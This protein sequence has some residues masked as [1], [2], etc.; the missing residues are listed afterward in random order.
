MV[1]ISNTLL[2][3]GSQ[4]IM[5]PLLSADMI[6]L[7][8]DLVIIALTGVAWALT[9]LTQIF[10]FQHKKFPLK[11]PVTIYPPFIAIVNTGWGY[12]SFQTPLS[13]SMVPF[14]HVQILISFM[15]ATTIYQS[16][17]KNLISNISYFV[18]FPLAIKGDTLFLGS[19]LE[20]IA[21]SIS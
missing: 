11:T 13:A 17:G 12:Y 1:S 4:P 3:Y 16:P 8:A 5:I 6:P 14:F 10:F 9:L 19:F 18:N 20:F 2:N 21:I 7:P 15:H